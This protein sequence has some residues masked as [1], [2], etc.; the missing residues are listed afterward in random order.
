MSYEKKLS[1]EKILIISHNSLSSTANNGKTLHSIF[2]CFPSDAI[3]QLYFQTEIPDSYKFNLFFR[4]T[5]LDIIKNFFKLNFDF[6]GKTYNL[7]SN[8]PRDVYGKHSTI[9]RH[10]KKLS[11]I[12]NLIREFIYSLKIYDGERLNVW[13]DDFK[14]TAIF[15]LGGESRFLFDIALKLSIKK[16]IPLH[17]F[18]TD[19][20]IFNT[21]TSRF[22]VLNKLFFNKVKESVLNAKSCFC[23]SDKMAV[24]YKSE[25]SRDF[26]I[27]NNAVDF[28]SNRLTKV[29]LQDSQ[30]KFI[31]AGGLTLGRDRALV[32]LCKLIGSVGLMDDSF[33]FQII[34]CSA[35]C[36][37]LDLMT[38]LKSIVG[39][40]I[41]VNG[42]MSA[43]EMKGV[44]NTA[45]FL[46]HVESAIPKYKS[47]TYLSISTK[48]SECLSSK[49]CLLAFG[50]PELASM[51]LISTNHVGLFL[52]SSSSDSV[53]KQL[54]YDVVSSQETYCFFVNSGYKYAKEHFSKD[55]LQNTLLT[56]L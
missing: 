15:V 52:N 32:D 28:N 54:I 11:S 48:I 12:K 23:I 26:Y 49:R 3:A 10:F 25:F 41:I 31:Y 33:D 44:Y 36:L 43:K 50:P 24:K 46:L 19:D 4:I 14:P 40:N 2:D 8:E 5:D 27:L 21:R 34:I 53:N 17:I 45:H 47:K 16:N 30:I 9:I 20:Y 1:K 37:S 35:N 6:G 22:N 29:S 39:V 7:N 38:E 55:V 56:H 42:F 13:I 51:E 18:F